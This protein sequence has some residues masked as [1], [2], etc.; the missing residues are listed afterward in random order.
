[1]VRVGWMRDGKIREEPADR[2]EYDG[3]L[4]VDVFRDEEGKAP[5]KIAGNISASHAT[6]LI[7]SWKREDEL[8]AKPKPRLAPK[9]KLW[10]GVIPDIFGYG[11]TVLSNSKDGAMKALKAEYRR[12]KKSQG[13]HADPTTTF[14]GSYE[15][16]G[17]HIKKIEVGKVYFD[18]FGE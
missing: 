15:N 6:T 18:N 14:A 13:E 2:G 11:M 3:E 12:W 10:V 16:F 17:G 4:F 9:S 7:E 8:K 1:M 5:D